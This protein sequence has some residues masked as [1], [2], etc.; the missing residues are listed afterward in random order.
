MR[1]S[2]AGATFAAQQSTTWQK[3]YRIR[4]G[5]EATMSELKRGHGMR[6]LRVRRQVRVSLA[7]S[8]KVTACN[9]KR[10]LRA[11]RRIDAP[12]AEAAAAMAA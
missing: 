5:A 8:F 2:I 10:W 7:V 3:T 12:P 1:R 11:L 6:R 9:V 4:A